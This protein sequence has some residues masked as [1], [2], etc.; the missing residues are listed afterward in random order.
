M[1]GPGSRAW[2]YAGTDGNGGNLRHGCSSME[3]GTADWVACDPGA[4][5]GRPNRSVG[6]RTGARLD[7]PI[8]KERRSRNLELSGLLREMLLL[9]AKKAADALSAAACLWHWLSL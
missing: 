1:G 9:R 8:L 5:D 2:R 4:R 7:G 3:G 6:G